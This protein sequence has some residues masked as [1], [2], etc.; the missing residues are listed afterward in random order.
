MIEIKVISFKYLIEINIIIIKY[1][2]WI[3][4][5]YISSYLHISYLF[6][7]LFVDLMYYNLNEIVFLRPQIK[8]TIIITSLK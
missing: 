8:K 2:V 3:F 7:I 4:K 6:P 5:P 1:L